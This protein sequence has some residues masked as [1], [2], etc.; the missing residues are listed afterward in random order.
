MTIEFTPRPSS[1]VH[2]ASPDGNYLDVRIDRMQ[3][4]VVGPMRHSPVEYMDALRDA[5]DNDSIELISA[6]FMDVAPDGLTPE[7][8]AE[9]NKVGM[10]RGF[11]SLVFEQQGVLGVQQAP[12]EADAADDGWMA[13]PAPAEGPPPVGQDDPT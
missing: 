2:L 13:G 3:V 12:D 6:E 10:Q 4:I 9:R 1:G 8:Q 11:V 7:A 5:F